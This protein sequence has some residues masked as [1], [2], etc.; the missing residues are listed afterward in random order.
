[1][2]IIVIGGGLSGLTFAALAA[3]DG[4]EVTVIEKNG[5]PG[6]V[7]AFAEQDGFRFEQGPLILSDILPGETLYS[8]LDTLDIHLE[9]VRADRGIVFPD[10]ELWKPDSY[11]GPDWR[12]KKLK[13]LFPEDS[14]GIDEYY[15][16]YE[17]LMKIR[18]LSLQKQTPL[19][20]LRTLLSSLP[21]KKYADLTAGELMRRL[22][23]NEKLRT[24][25]IGIL[26]DF[27]ADPDEAPCLMIPFVNIET[28]FDKRIPLEKNGKQYYAGYANFKGGVGKLPEALAGAVERYGGKIV[29]NTVADRVIVEDGAVRGVQLSD[30]TVLPADVV[31]GCG[32]AKDF[33]GNTVGLEHLDDEYRH[34]LDT[35]MPMEAVF[36]LH[37]GVDFDPL[38]YQ[39]AALCYYYGTYDLH[40]AT[41]R[42]RTGVYHEGNDG[43]LIYVPSAHAP[44]LAPE[45]FHCLTIYTVA[46]DTL[47]ESSW[48]EKKEEYA[49]RLIKLAE[50]QLPGLSGHIVTRKIMTAEDYRRF[51]HMSKSSFG[52]V[53]PAMNVKN[54]PH[55]TPV[56]GL[57]FLGQ[58]SEN[59]GGVTAVINGARDA[60]E[61]MKNIMK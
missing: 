30:G 60:Y 50:R 51:T 26:A 58:Q 9:T 10:F 36:M 15:R 23:S 28:A 2:K 42:L 6:G 61:S 56:R 24:V 33:F 32:S 46:P 43:Y 34:I 49:D 29:Y 20:K 48:E 39:K 11:E 3:K 41:E 7:A 22:F 47:K 55:V 8:F 16:F 17:T 14:R 45:G 38:Q 5:V 54:P 12:K 21:L 37:L 52:G 1:M 18:F 53:V 25:F 31:T 40:A 35:F 57:Y 19:I 13:E 59:A 4:H 27:C 44:E